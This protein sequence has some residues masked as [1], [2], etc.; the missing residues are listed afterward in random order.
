MSAVEILKLEHVLLRLGVLQPLLRIL[1]EH[2][3]VGLQRQNAIPA[4]AD[5]QLRLLLSGS[6]SPKGAEVKF[7]SQGAA[8]SFPAACPRNESSPEFHPIFPPKEDRVG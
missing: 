1:V 8:H 7:P 4:L 6:N 3:L 2:S 5:D